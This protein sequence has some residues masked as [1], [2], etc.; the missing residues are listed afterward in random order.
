[1]NSVRSNSPS[2]KYEKAPGCKDIG[3]GQFEFGAKSQFLSIAF[4]CNQAFYFSYFSRLARFTN[5]Y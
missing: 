4:L 1:M 2:L 3:I 5:I